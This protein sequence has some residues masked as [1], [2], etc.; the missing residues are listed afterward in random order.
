MGSISE[1]IKEGSSGSSGTRD[2]EQYATGFNKKSSRPYGGLVDVTKGGAT[3][4]AFNLSTY[5]MEKDFFEGFPLTVS[6]N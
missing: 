4:R 2:A 6:N 1:P 5:F 3:A